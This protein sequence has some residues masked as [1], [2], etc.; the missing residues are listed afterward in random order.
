MTTPNCRTC[1]DKGMIPTEYGSQPCPMCDAYEALRARVS[2]RRRDDDIP[3]EWVAVAAYLIALG[4]G[5][6]VLIV[7]AGL[8][9]VVAWR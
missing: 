3:S 8:F 5:L 2:D 1:N 6:I 7:I 4:I 9:E